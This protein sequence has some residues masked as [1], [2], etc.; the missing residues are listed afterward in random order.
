MM[1]LVD[2]VRYVLRKIPKGEIIKWTCLQFSSSAEPYLQLEKIDEVLSKYKSVS[3]DLDPDVLWR[4]RLLFRFCPE[5][6]DE[7]IRNVF[8]T[9][10][11]YDPRAFSGEMSADD[12]RR[13]KLGLMND[14]AERHRECVERLYESIQAVFPGMTPRERS[15]LNAYK[16]KLAGD[17]CSLIKWYNKYSATHD[18]VSYDAWRKGS[19]RCNIEDLIGKEYRWPSDEFLRFFAEIAVFYYPTDLNPK[20]IEDGRKLKFHEVCALWLYATKRYVG[21]ASALEEAKANRLIEECES[22]TCKDKIAVLRKIESLAKQGNIHAL[23]H[24]LTSR[25]YNYSAKDVNLFLMCAA[26]L[27]LDYEK[28]GEANN[29]RR[30]RNWKSSLA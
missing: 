23:K 26:L 27:N 9:I 1:N 5:Y 13:A 8:S 11:Y 25:N 14:L 29:A 7:E 19:Q 20:F 18:D 2:Y 21:D 16:S 30:K 15:Y 22:S 28:D 4:L 3:Y 17:K 10:K 12:I 24:V 6:F